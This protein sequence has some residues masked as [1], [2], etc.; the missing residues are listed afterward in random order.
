M[1]QEA[2]M[3]SVIN[4]AELPS[5]EIRWEFQGAHYG[6]T[7]TSFI[8]VDA[9]PGTGPTLHAHPYE[10]IFVVLEGQVTFTVGDTTIEVSGGQIVIVLPGAHV[11]QFRPRA[12]PPD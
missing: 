2:A 5:D 4:R 11:R 8:L 1:V 6:D 3:T 10:E 9:P 7:N 12:A